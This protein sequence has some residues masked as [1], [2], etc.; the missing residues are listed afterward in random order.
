[1]LQKV[2]RIVSGIFSPLWLPTYAIFI[3]LNTSYLVMATPLS[4]WVVTVAV[5]IITGLIPATALLAMK[6]FGL[7]DDMDLEKRHQRTS[8]FVVILVCYIG[9]ILMLSKV[10]CPTEVCYMMGGAALAVL[11]MI[12]ISQWWKISAHAAGMGALLAI[13]YRESTTMLTVM[14]L[15]WLFMSVAFI[16]GLVGMSRLVL[17][18]HTPWQVMAGWVL[19]YLCVILATI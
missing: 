18:R 1:M 9:C 14:P 15:T 6:R 19:G 3:I 5:L 11:L 8:P 7:I 16:S 13:I 4:R 2:A 17:E 10:N 12:I